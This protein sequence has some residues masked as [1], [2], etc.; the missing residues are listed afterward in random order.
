MRIWKSWIWPGVAAVA[1]LT[2]LALWL[3]LDPV[4]TDLRDR[5]TT[6][7]SVNHGWASVSLNGRDLTLQ[8]LAPDLESQA[9][10]I[11][12][13]RQTYGVRI[14]TDATGLL[15]EQA[16]YVLSLEKTENGLLLNGFAPNDATRRQL[17]AL[18]SENLPGIALLDQL[19]LARGAPDDFVALA[20]FGFAPFSR[21]STGL[22]EMTGSVLR[23]H[24]RALNP[25]DHEAALELVAA[26]PPGGGSLESVEITPAPVS[27][28]YVWS[29][30]LSP[31]Q[32]VLSGYVPDQAVRLA[33]VEAAKA[34]HPDLDVIDAMR[35]AAGM[36]E[37]VDWLAAASDAISLSSRLTEG[38]ASLSGSRLNMSGEIADGDG[39]R[40]LQARLDAGLAA[41]VELGT[42][43]IGLARVSPFVWSAALSAEGLVF[44]GVVPS[45]AVAESLVETAGLKFGNLKIDDRQRI[46]A[47]APEG[48]E[49]AALA[50]LQA[51]SRLDEAAVVL[52]YSSLSVN[53][54]ALSANTAG[55][56][57]RQ[58]E[59]DLPKTFGSQ[60]TVLL[61]PL[62][63]EGLAGAACQDVLNELLAAN[64][65]LFD[66]GEAGIQHHSF[67]FLDRI[68]FAARQC[69]DVRLEISGH[70][71]ADGAE[72]ANQTLSERRAEAVVAHMIAAGV[73]PDS[74]IAIGYGESRPVADN[75][76]DTGKAA[77]RRIEFRV[78]N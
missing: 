64:S 9:S 37:G 20:A 66:T 47:G 34:D 56:L 71:D 15:P 65:I 67:G 78:V 76:T 2:F 48:F 50:A 52:N 49:T 26:S 77:N 54:E 68:A 57:A 33:L 59:E 45:R 41:G 29:V 40:A 75:E 51:L 13:A 61:K 5:A 72:S 14:V 55:D 19:K 30:K 11:D 74:M 73:R 12:I 53:G 22:M 60:Q 32:V 43:D 36:P 25:E 1:F 24:G 58:L 44:D 38:S 21:F 7:L 62:P 27:G 70:T 63:S 35:F 28:E 4:E 6:A 69:R 10:A 31:A 3:R 16:P 39:F 46:A 17:V 8:G 42:F 18:L 23:I